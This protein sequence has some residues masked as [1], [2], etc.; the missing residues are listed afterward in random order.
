MGKAALNSH[1]KCAGRLNK[2]AAMQS[3]PSSAELIKNVEKIK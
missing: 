3:T 1:A 2:L